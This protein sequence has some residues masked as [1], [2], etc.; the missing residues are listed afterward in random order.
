ML[1][2]G[3]GGQCTPTGG[4]LLSQKPGSWLASAVAVAGASPASVAAK[5]AASRRAVRS[6][7]SQTERGCRLG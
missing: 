6:E 1:N 5:G 2:A 7:G 3:A 4:A